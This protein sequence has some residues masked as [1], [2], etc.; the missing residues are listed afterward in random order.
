MLKRILYGV[1]FGVFV[2][3][4]DASVGD[5][6]TLTTSTTRAIRH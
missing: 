5:M 6:F 2:L 1:I 4:A 3:N